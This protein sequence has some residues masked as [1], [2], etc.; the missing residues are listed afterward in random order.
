LKQFPFCEDLSKIDKTL[1]AW[2]K[3]KLSDL[4]KLDAGQCSVLLGRMERNKRYL[5]WFWH[6]ATGH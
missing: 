1:V 6:A 5:T 2:N 4:W 3:V